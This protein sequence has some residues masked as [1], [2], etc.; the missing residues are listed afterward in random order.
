MCVYVGVG[1]CV[2]VCVWSLE[3]IVV[4]S[5][6]IRTVIDLDV[7][8]E[9]TVERIVVC[10]KFA[11]DNDEVWSR[12]LGRHTPKGA[13][14]KVLKSGLEGR[15]LNSPQLKEGGGKNHAKQT[16]VGRRFQ[17]GEYN[18]KFPTGDLNKHVPPASRCCR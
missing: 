10:G 3:L 16:A 6:R 4:N 2:C 9:E 12:P 8:K 17:N 5:P 18:H 11:R 15:W 14:S 13:V 7:T 1:V